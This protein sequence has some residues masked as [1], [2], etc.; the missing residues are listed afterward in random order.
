MWAVRLTPQARRQLKQLD[1]NIREDAISVLLDLEDGMFPAETIQLRKHERYERVKF[2]GNRFR[3]VYRIDRKNKRIL[4]TVIRK[5]N[6][7]P[8]K[9]Y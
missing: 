7:N 2:A 9:G 1:E 4:V 5:R 8:Y 6:E 3:I